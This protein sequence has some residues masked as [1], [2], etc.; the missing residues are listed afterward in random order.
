[1]KI[2]RKLLEKLSTKHCLL[3]L[4]LIITLIYIAQMYVNNTYSSVGM[5]LVKI[6]VHIKSLELENTMLEN[7]IASRSAIR[8]IDSKA[9]DLGFVSPKKVEYIK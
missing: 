8:Y 7:E 3:G 6:Q 9:K 4:W 1:M 2:V 5:D